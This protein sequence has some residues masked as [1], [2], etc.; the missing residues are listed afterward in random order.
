MLIVELVILCVLF[1]AICYINT[2]GDD[3]NI[4]LILSAMITWRNGILKMGVSNTGQRSRR[5][6]RRADEM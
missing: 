6:R 5:F 3:N 1:W 4:M 2:G